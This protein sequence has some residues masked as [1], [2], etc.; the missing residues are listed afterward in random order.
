M[1][2]LTTTEPVTQPNSTY[3]PSVRKKDHGP[4][5][6]RDG[7]GLPIRRRTGDDVVL[8]EEVAGAGVL[9]NESVSELPRD[10]PR[11]LP[12]ADDESAR[13]S[14]VGTRMSLHASHEPSAGQG[15][16]VLEQ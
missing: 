6:G 4:P 11:V 10:S 12:V 14:P 3:S 1:G 2:V 13:G 15:V 7:I 9:P 8:L 5:A 16:A